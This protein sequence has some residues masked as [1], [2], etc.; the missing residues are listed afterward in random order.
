MALMR[1]KPTSPARRG[2]IKVVNHTL[3]KGSAYGPLL[4]GKSKTG[5]RNNKGQITTRHIGGGH[6]RQY[7]LIDFKRNKDNV[8][9]TVERIEY[10]PNRSAHIALIL[11]KDGERRY[12]VAP[13]G[14]KTGDLLVSGQ[15][16]PIKLGNSL[17]LSNIPLGST[18]HCVE[19]KPGKGAQLARSAG[20]AMQ[21][22][23]REAGYAILR[24]RS[25]EVRRVL[26]T[27]RA[28]LGAVSN[29]E[30]NLRKLGKAGAQ[31]WRG[32]RPTVR[33]VAMNP[34][35]HPHGGGEGKTSRGGPPRS[36]WGQQTKSLRTRKNKRTDS[37]RIRRRGNK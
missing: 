5:G 9:G 33:G 30:N 35:D 14:I 4:V 17:P 18:I 32:I 7:R 23:G 1:A 36:P 27:C 3:Y 34:I 6:K 22:L 31:R 28:T 25:R 13:A 2:V 21:L 10:D 37:M 19:L 24:M 8:P 15:T 29:A 12:I 16:V 11:Y 26:E 20:A